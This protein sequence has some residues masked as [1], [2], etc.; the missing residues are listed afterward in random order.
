MVEVATKEK[1]N[2]G[3]T[4]IDLSGVG[5]DEEGNSVDVPPIRIYFNSLKKKKKI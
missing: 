1:L 4:C 5:D 2:I 3:C